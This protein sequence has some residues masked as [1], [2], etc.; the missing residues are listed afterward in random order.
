MNSA[1]GNSFRIH[2]K[3]LSNWLG[4]HHCIHHFITLENHLNLPPPELPPPKISH[5]I[6]MMR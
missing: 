2:N 3:K 4:H 1:L 6:N 5:R